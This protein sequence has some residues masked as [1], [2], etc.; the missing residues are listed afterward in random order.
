MQIQENN[1]FYLFLV[2]AIIYLIIQL[3]RF[4]L[5]PTLFVVGSAGTL[6]GGFISLKNYVKSFQQNVSFEKPKGV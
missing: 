5:L 3:I 2:I 4:V 1:I 6:Y